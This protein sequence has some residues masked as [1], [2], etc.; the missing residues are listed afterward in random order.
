MYSF[1]KND[2][3]CCSAQFKFKMSD[4]ANLKRF[5][6]SPVFFF[7]FLPLPLLEN[8]LLHPLPGKS[9]FSVKS[10]SLFRQHSK[11]YSDKHL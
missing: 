4:Y 8:Y 5:I 1:P 7:F 11:R 3:F 2:L 10:K 6:N 9:V